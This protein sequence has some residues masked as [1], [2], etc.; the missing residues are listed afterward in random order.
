MICRTERAETGEVGGSRFCRAFY[1]TLRSLDFI[2]KEICNYWER[3][4][5]RLGTD[6]VSCP[7]PTQTPSPAEEPEEKA[8]KPRCLQKHS[9]CEEQVS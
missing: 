9:F 4:G 3:V 7:L 8:R 1:A 2:Q 5:F 6:L